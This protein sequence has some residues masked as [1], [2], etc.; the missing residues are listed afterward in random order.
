MFSIN[1]RCKNINRSLT[2]FCVYM[3]EQNT[4]CT[5]KENHG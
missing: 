2:Q 4:E 1:V 3:S 5:T